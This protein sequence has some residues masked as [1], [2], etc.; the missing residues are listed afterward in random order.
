MTTMTKN[1]S[2]TLL[3]NRNHLVFGKFMHGSTPMWS[4]ETMTEYFYPLYPNGTPEQKKADELRYQRELE[5]LHENNRQVDFKFM[6]R[7]FSPS[8]VSSR[9][10]TFLGHRKYL[11]YAKDS[12][13]AG[14]G[15]HAVFFHPMYPNGTPEQ[16]AAD[17][18]RYQRELEALHDANSAFEQKLLARDSR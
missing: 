12:Q 2:G 10:G 17:E 4:V 8:S 15:L 9:G 16:K 11:K 14:V 18:L 3:G 1:G 13:P 6:A 5:A 7:D